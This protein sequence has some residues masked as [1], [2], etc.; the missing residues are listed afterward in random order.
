MAT[1]VAI[2]SNKWIDPKQYKATY[3]LYIWYNSQESDEAPIRRT[4]ILHYY[5]QIP[6]IISLLS[7]VLS[8]NPRMLKYMDS[9]VLPWPLERL[10]IF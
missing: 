5:L 2:A 10:L 6:N 1:T 9:W 4:Y 3:G 7:K 8:A